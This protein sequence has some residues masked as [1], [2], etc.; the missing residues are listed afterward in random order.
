MVADLPS[1]SIFCP[2]PPKRSQ[3]PAPSSRLTAC[4]GL[5][6]LCV[7][8]IIN[9]AQ[10]DLSSV[11][12]IC[13]AVEEAQWYYEDFIRPLDPSLPSM[14]LRNFCIRIFTHCPLL[15]AFSQGD[16]MTA[17]EQF[18]KYK[19]RIPVRGAIMLNE[20]M[21]SAVLVKG[22]KKGANWSFPRGKINKDEDDLTCA[23]REVYEETGFDLD[24]AGLVPENRDVK[25]IDMTIR[26]QELR[27]Y[28]FRGVPMDTH[29]EPKTR[30][31]I[32]KIQWW[33]ISDLP[34][35]QKKG[36]QQ[37]QADAAVSTNKFYMVAPFIRGVRKWV[38]EQKKADLARATSNQYSSAGMSHDELMTEEEQGAES[39]VHTHDQA[40]MTPSV[41]DINQ[42][43]AALKF[44]LKI[45][46][47]TQG[48]QVE[49]ITA[50][51][52]PVRDSGQELLALLQG[53]TR[54]SDRPPS[55]NLPPATPLD[56]TYI[57]APVPKTPHHQ[58]PRPPHFSTLPPP[59][60]FPIQPPNDTLYRP[61]QNQQHHH[62]P[63]SI[64]TFPHNPMQGQRPPQPARS[65][66]YQSQHLV[67]PQ[68]LPPQVQRT[69][70]TGGPVYSS[71]VSPPT[72]APLAPHANSTVSQA[73]NPQFPN[74]H[75]L[76]GPSIQKQSPPKLTS[77]SLALLNTFKSHDQA[78]SA[79]SIPSQPPLRK[80]A[81]E[82]KQGP[83]QE[84]PAEVS[85]TPPVDLLSL[86]KT[87]AEPSPIPNSS[88]MRSR[89]PV[90]E[91][92]RSSLL[93]LFK[94]P[95]AQ[96]SIS[97][98]PAAATAF[99]TSTTPSA[100]ELSAVEPLSS[101]A[102]PASISI[103]DGRDVN[104]REKNEVI[105]E[106][107]PESNLPFRAMSIL[108]RPSQPNGSDSKG[109]NGAADQTLSNKKEATTSQSRRT[110]SKVSSEKPFQPQI[111]KR[112]Q[113]STS[114][115]TE[116]LNPSS[117]ASAA[118]PVQPSFDRRASQT[119]DHKQT[120]LSLFGKAPSPA[121]SVTMN[122]MSDSFSSLHAVDP[123]TS[124]PAK[125][126]VSSLASDSLS[127]RGSQ[128]ALSPADKSFL[129][130]YL[131]NVAKGTQR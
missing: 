24:A 83:P 20:A 70:F 45:Q 69:V 33:R 65:R 46:Q 34:S 9:L 85:G 104:P 94:N 2:E 111:L 57:Q 32:S 131:D 112:P 49:A 75:P 35:F 117:S 89:P 25:Y 129:L 118:L 87:Q 93:D 106:L 128:S 126:R 99:P 92:H 10:D 91:A 96:T 64:A 114:K 116:S 18:L 123:T 60:A 107:H 19:M 26:D 68:P 56:H 36:H 63:N 23:I 15:S 109:R 28:I 67:H 97:P 101:N 74:A 124:V 11:E 29:F 102:T 42:L 27:L 4:A 38:T 1:P 48:L 113:P 47:P 31:E 110:P 115:P 105:P 84:L 79:A 95:S 119:A 127:R 7:R 71:T 14:S 81:Q 51:Q 37:Q 73:L 122:S 72:Q 88:T 6:D 108:T 39:N 62:Q 40:H 90:S 59:P 53:K 77:H 120:L 43:E 50:M 121:N 100:V 54:E 21:D 78:S 44:A 55:S 82:V 80:F 5:D 125:T 3:P 98:R 52:S 16:H 76:M 12:R 58:Q 66:S 61:E 22:W 103:A 130:S 30:K 86:F 41:A 17:F 13:F 8:F